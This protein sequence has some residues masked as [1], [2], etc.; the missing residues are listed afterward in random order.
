MTTAA[1]PTARPLTRELRAVRV[2]WWREVLRLVRNRAQTALMLLNPLLF[3]L[4][5]GVGLDGM[6]G[7][8]DGD[9]LRYVFPGVLLLA[10]QVPALSAGASIVRD[11]EAGFLRGL[12]VAPVRRGTLLIGKCLGGATAATAQGALLLA[13][14]GVAGLPYRP[15]LLLALLAELA[16]A[17]LT[18]TMV[19]AF[20][21]VFVRRLETFQMLLS[22]AMMPL[23]FLSGALFSLKGLPAWLTVPSLLN[24]LTYA[25]DALRRTAAPELSDGPRVAGWAPPIALE[26]G[27]M[28]ALTAVLLAAAATRFGRGTP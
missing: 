10:V 5:L 8:S 6:T 13:L 25:V 14:A 22:I 2:L 3:L 18:M 4:V 16:L 21:A 15:A 27:L 20:A 7:A 28:L 11:G 1:A 19:G 23:F 17:A 12:L 26:L 9:Y 24:P